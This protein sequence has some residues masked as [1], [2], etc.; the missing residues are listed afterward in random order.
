M[1]DIITVGCKTSTGGSV[2]TGSGHVKINGLSQALL[3]DTATCLCGSKSCRGQ[4]PIVQQSSRAAN[5]NGTNVARVGD[6]VD[7]GCGNCDL[8]ASNHNVSLGTSTATPLSMGSGI[9]I[10]NGVN[11]NTEHSLTKPITQKTHTTTP[12]IF[13][14]QVR[15]KTPQGKPIPNQPYF[16]STAQRTY[17]G[18][19]D[20]N[21]CLPRIPT[22]EKEDIRVYLGVSALEKWV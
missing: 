15:L 6:F 14:E 20:S 11:I 17:Q 10:G 9:S 4:G 5:I 22:N 21:G 16:I 13:D 18:I 3:G 1:G 12:L 19:S 7:T 8:I 2:I